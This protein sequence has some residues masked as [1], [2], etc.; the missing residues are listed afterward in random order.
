ME[1]AGDDQGAL[2]KAVNDYRT[3]LF[4]WND[5][6]NRNLALAYRYFGEAVWKGLGKGIYED[7]KRIGRHLERSYSTRLNEPQATVPSYADELVACAT[8]STS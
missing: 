4:E 3:S 1:A 5:N 2:E 8:G 6:L 7:F